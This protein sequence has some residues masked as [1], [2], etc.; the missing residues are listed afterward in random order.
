MHFAVV[1][2]EDMPRLTTDLRARLA[3]QRFGTTFADV[4]ADAC[5]TVSTRPVPE[6]FYQVPRSDTPV[7][8]L[9]GGLDP[10][11]PSRHGAVVA[12]RLGNAR[13]IVSP[14]LGHGLSA[15]ACAPRLIT[16]F[17]RDADFRDLDV[18]CLENLPAAAF[19]EAIE[20]APPA[21]PGAAR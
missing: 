12:E 18:G 6:S 8:V 21:Q 16:K 7:L 14:Y 4:Y 19:F 15:Q 17:I 9:S 20:P 5:S 3:G 1:C 11:T 13:H 10:A 2:G